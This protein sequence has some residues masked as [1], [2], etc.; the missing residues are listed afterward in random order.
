[1]V[2]R[3]GRWQLNANTLG[4]QPEAAVTIMAKVT[5]RV[6]L[7]LGACVVSLASCILLLGHVPVLEVDRSVSSGAAYGFVI[8]MSKPDALAVVRRQ[9]GAT[10]SAYWERAGAP[11]RLSEYEQWSAQGRGR[12]GTYTVS[13]GN[14]TALTLPLGYSTHWRVNLGT[15]GVNTIEL[16]FAGDS[17]MEVRR[18]RYLVGR[19]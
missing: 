18:C 2:L 15:F 13:A 12:I 1:M 11:S 4:G 17:L 6:L 3:W 16:R 10:L 8:G 5:T 7:A 19:P 14:A 9:R